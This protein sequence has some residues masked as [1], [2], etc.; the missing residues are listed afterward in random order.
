MSNLVKDYKELRV[1]GNAIE[2]TMELFE[3]TKTFPTE[4]IGQLIT[5]INDADA[6]LV[7]DKRG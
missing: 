6:W 5:M 4:I 2:A 7:K 3:I 1:Y